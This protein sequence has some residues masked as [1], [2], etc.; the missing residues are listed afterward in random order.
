MLLDRMTK[1][2]SV[3]AYWR[4]RLLSTRVVSC[5][6]YQ[7]TKQLRQYIKGNNQI[8]LIIGQI[9]HLFLLTRSMTK[10]MIL[11]GSIKKSPCWVWPHCL[12]HFWH[13]T[14]IRI[15]PMTRQAGPSSNLFIYLPDVL[16]VRPIKIEVLLQIR[17]DSFLSSTMLSAEMATMIYLHFVWFLCAHDLLMSSF[18]SQCSCHLY[19][20][21]AG[22][23][24]QILSSH[25]WW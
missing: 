17:T 23:L 22:R 16:W 24:Q 7:L 8:C 10:Q 18:Y 20:S 14:T 9:H 25:G 3:A 21:Q 2:G 5:C 6:V 4:W 13:F 19:C 12:I 1:L 11:K 15:W